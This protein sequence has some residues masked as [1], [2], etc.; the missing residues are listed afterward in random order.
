M[1]NDDM[2]QMRLTLQ[3]QIFLYVLKGELTLVSLDE[4]SHILDVG[5]GTGEWA[6]RMAELFPDCEVIGTD[7]SAIAETSSVPMNL[8]IE[9]EDAE[10]WDRMPDRY[11][12]IHLR[13]MEG[14]FRNWRLVYENILYSLKPGGW[15]EVLDFDNGEGIKQFMSSFGRDAPMTNLWHDV[16]I[17][18]EKSG[19]PKGDGHLN[20]RLL[21]DAGFV[22]VRVTEFIVPID[23]AE[24]TAGKIWLITVLD[25][26]EATFLRLLTEQ[27][28]WEAEKCKVACEAAA[29]QIAEMAK[30]R[31]KSRGLSVK[32]RVVVGRKPITATP[33]TLSHAAP[34]RASSV[35]F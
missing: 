7:I 24:Q 5:T 35:E 23:I 6:T 16:L 17:A 21:M 19:R 29:R 14:A 34:S 1:P 12:L 18:A 9:I 10:D 20:P 30:D 22:D 28:G 25:A 33:S 4:P 11:D 32:I 8:F 26:I 2:E 31:E 27:M 15:I 13:N 3:H